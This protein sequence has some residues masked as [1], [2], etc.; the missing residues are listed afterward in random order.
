[1]AGGKL[2]STGVEFPD[3]TTQTTSGLPL[4]G[5]ALT[6]AVTTTSTFDGRDVAAD[7]VTA[8]A[9]LP[10]AGGTM[11]GDTLHGDNVKAKF[12]AGDDL[13]ISHNGTNSLIQDAGTGIL[14]LSSNGS[15]IKLSDTSGNNLARFFTGGETQLHCAG[16]L[17]LATKT[18]GVDVT[19]SVTC[20]GFTSTGIDDNATS[21]AITIDASENVGIG[22][23]VP[24][25]TLD[26]QGTGV[27]LRNPSYYSGTYNLNLN[28]DSATGD[29]KVKYYG[30][31]RL[32]V[33]ANGGITFNGDTAAANALDDYEEGTWTPGIS[34]GGGVVGITYQ[35]FLGKYTKVGNL[36]TASGF[37]QLTAKGTS[38]GVALI[39]GLPFTS[40][41][42]TRNYASAAIR[43]KGVSFADYI[44]AHNS[45][46]TTTLEL[47]ES[48]NAGVVTQ[49][50]N[51]SFGDTSNIM[52]NVSYKV[53]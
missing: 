23:S 33:R 12:G 40:A 19:G 27:N 39:T 44:M 20:D 32:R 7:G 14:E 36:V 48:T 2:I 9:A 5:G 30:T 26:V 13:Q 8:D 24:S 29:F 15:E 6:G 52:I 46:N 35:D 38:T 31:E 50:D 34:F 4:T 49:I 21:T 43:V 45:V 11:T 17:K 10:K 41:N 28:Q 25:A 1:M 18:T 47:F 16:N 22:R 53:A 3:A 37:F 42:I 51:T